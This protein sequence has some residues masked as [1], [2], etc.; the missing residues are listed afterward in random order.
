M[1]ELRF[2]GRTVVITGAGR[3]IGRCHALLFASRGARV[4]V[5][6]YG[7]ALDGSGS[8]NGPADEVVSEIKAA[9]GEAVSCFADVSDE[10]GAASIVEAALD[11]F[12]QIDALVNNAGIASPLDWIDNLSEA[13]YRR[14]VEIHYL[15]TVY[16]TK[17]AWPHLKASDAARLV[18]TTSEGMLGTVPKNSSYAGAKGAVLGFTR[19][20]AVD[21]MRDGIGVNAVLPRADTRMAAA[22]VLAH[23]YDAPADMFEDM[24]AIDP[25]RVSPA[26]VYLAH[27][28]CTLQGELL[29]SGGG[30]VLRLALV[31]AQGIYD[32]NVSPEM[33]AEN[34]D[35]VLDI[36]DGQVMNAGV[37]IPAP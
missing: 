23:V 16:V 3:G 17:A 25:V 6:D 5:A 27:E 15:G 7:V 10:A 28:S 22:D 2:D 30:H 34:I 12:G 36:T 29:V 4:V 18:N 24:S 1:N 21:G 19:A 14:M 37:S 11:T 31:E 26:V 32:E 33:V 8:S 9:G 35:K 20:L 13:D